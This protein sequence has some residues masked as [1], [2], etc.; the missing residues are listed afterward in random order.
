MTS[1]D[2][3][4]TLVR[5]AL[6]EFDERPLAV[7]IRRAIRIASLAGDSQVAVRLAME[8][9][10]SDGDPKANGEATRRL[11]ADPALWASADGP[12]EA[13]MREYLSDRALDRKNPESLI[14]GHS[15]SEIE[16]LLRALEPELASGNVS[17]SS[18]ESAARLRNV[19]ELA[20]YRTFAYLCEWERRFGYSSINDSIFGGY[21]AVV[22]RLL[23]VHA[24]DLVE[25]FNTL[26]RRLNEA[27]DQ[28]HTRPA[29]EE[30]SQALT[31]CRRILEAVV[32]QVLP[33]QAEPSAAGY[34]LDQASYRSRLFEFIKIANESKNVSAATT[35]MA[36]GLH[37]RF[38][39]FDKLTGAAY[40]H[41]PSGISPW[42]HRARPGP[43]SPV[44]MRAFAGSHRRAVEARGGG[45]R[46]TPV[47][48]NASAP[49]PQ[50]R[51]SRGVAPR[52]AATRNRLGGP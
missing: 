25:R 48:A 35:A 1:A 17:P 39:A 13:A 21:K 33:A 6:N 37:A 44:R 31:T 4:L 27:A 28:D 40:Q 3:I 45:S 50:G 49:D 52:N 15:L 7:S 46:C 29:G 42:L 5:T 43:H 16:Y 8:L 14:A 9:R 51:R 10:P 23:S 41:D 32:G 18:F 22:D 19:Q 12:A 24:P 47:D 34:K 36:E 38:A 26:Y 20:R 11:M 30:L 2:Q